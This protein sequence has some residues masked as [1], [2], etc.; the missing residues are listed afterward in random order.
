MIKIAFIGPQRKVIK[1]EIDGKVVKYIDELWKEG[2]QIYPL[3]EVLLNKLTTSNSRN[4]RMMAALIMDANKGKDFEEYNSCKTEEDLDKFI[5]KD[6]KLKG[7][8]K[9]K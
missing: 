4:L 7:L 1:F 9:V 6:C 5:T 3:D 2:L 8:I